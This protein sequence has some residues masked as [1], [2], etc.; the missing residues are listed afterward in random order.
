MRVAAIVPLYPPGSR[1][2]AWLAT[3]EFVKA[4]AAAGHNVV[5]VPFLQGLDHELEFEGVKVLPSA[6]REAAIAQADLVISHLGDGGSNH[7]MALRHGKPSVRL[8]HSATA[9]ATDLQ[10]SAMIVCNSEAT[11]SML[12]FAGPVEVVHPITRPERFATTP[13]DRITLVNLA[14]EKG[15]EL[16]WKLAEK[17]PSLPF[18]GVLGGYGQQIRESLP[19]VEVISTTADMRGDVYAR[20]RLLLMPSRHESWGM[21]A[22]EAAASGIP[23]LARPTAGLRES[24]GAGGNWQNGFSAGMWV[25]KVRALMGDGWAEASARALA[26]SGELDPDASASRFVEIIEGVAT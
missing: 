11:R 8:M 20:T 9:Q 2:G 15:G 17:L 6:L 12:R 21:V 26:R 16:F 24:L 22:V 25:P 7:R 23:T 13:G 3:H 1:V 10:G 14:P 4:L 5:V 18:L 19:N